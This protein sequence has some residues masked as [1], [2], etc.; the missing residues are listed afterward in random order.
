MPLTVSASEPTDDAG[1]E[2]C[3]TLNVIVHAA[4]YSDDISRVYTKR[5]ARKETGP[6]LLREGNLDLNALDSA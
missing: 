1:T 6:E 2:A 4:A 3:R 5:L